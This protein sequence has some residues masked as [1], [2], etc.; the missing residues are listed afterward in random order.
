M[1]LSPKQEEILREDV[2]FVNQ[3]NQTYGSSWKKRGGVGAFMMLARKY[4]RMRQ[5]N[6]GTVAYTPTIAEDHMDLRCYLLLVLSERLFG[7][8]VVPVEDT[9][10]YVAIG[11][12][13]TTAPPDEK[14]DQ[15]E[16]RCRYKNWDVFQVPNYFIIT[17]YAALLKDCEAHEL[18]AEPGPGYVNQDR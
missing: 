7:T 15:L 10:P 8:D 2:K 6:G 5:M 18:A 4:D 3:R 11:T 1:N 16:D 9:I 17:T 12:S 14:L 13:H